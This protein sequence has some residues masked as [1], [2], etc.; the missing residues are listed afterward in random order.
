MGNVTDTIRANRW[1]MVSMLITIG[2][3]LVILALVRYLYWRGLWLAS[4]WVHH[5]LGV[6][7][8]LSVVLS[9]GTAIIGL[10]KDQSRGYG[11]LALCLSLLS[12]LFYVQ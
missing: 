4:P 3:A 12:F 5:V 9:L 10:A 11:L 2:D 1:S 6:W 7:G 8:G